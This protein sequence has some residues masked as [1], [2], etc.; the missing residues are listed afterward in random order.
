MRERPGLLLISDQG[1]ASKLFERSLSPQGTTLL[2]APRKREVTRPGELMLK[3]VR[4][5]IESVNDTFKGRLD[6]AQH[7]ARTVEGV[8]VRVARRVLALAAAIW[9]NFQTGRAVSR[10]LTAYEH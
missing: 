2:R 8:A 3:K 10:P 9:H 1:F 5:L 6:L 7:G 4:R